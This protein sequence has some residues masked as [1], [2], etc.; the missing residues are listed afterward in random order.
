M[1][2][3]IKS[4][5]TIFPDQHS[6]DIQRVQLLEDD[7][8]SDISSVCSENNVSYQQSSSDSEIDEVVPSDFP[9]YTRTNSYS[10]RRHQVGSV[11]SISRWACVHSQYLFSN[12]WHSK[13][14]HQSISSNAL[15]CMEAIH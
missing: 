5:P 8:G 14:I 11:A 6:V 9:R 7:S 13:R 4:V 10:Q 1:F 3:S 15:R 12:S 2:Q